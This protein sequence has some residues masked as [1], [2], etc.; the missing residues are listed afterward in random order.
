M[1]QE[2]LANFYCLLFIND[3]ICKESVGITE[4]SFWFGAT[5]KMFWSKALDVMHARESVS[6]LQSEM[7]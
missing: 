6:K 7:L 1:I 3:D 4:L 5:V 2:V